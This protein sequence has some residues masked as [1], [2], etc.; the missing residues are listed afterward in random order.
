MKRIF[1][2][3]LDGFKDGINIQKYMTIAQCSKGSATNDLNELVDY[4]CI[5]ELPG[6]GKTKSYKIRFNR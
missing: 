4:G 1:K 2:G 5:E 3:G 6:D